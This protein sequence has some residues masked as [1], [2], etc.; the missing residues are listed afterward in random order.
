VIAGKTI[1]LEDFVDDIALP[2]IVALPHIAALLE[3]NLR[4]AAQK[5][6]EWWR[7]ARLQEALLDAMDPDDNYDF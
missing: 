1:G 7:E 6:E 5:V 2:H 4:L 3:Q